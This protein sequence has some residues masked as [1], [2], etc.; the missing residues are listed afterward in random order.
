VLRE[1]FDPKGS[2]SPSKKTR[3]SDAAQNVNLEIPSDINP[4]LPTIIAKGRQLNSLLREIAESLQTDKSLFR[5]G[6]GLVS[7]RNGKIEHYS[8]ESMPKL[9]SDWANYVD[10]RGNGVFPPTTAAKAILYSIDGDDGI[11]PLERVVNVPTLRQDGT[12]LD[13]PGYDEAS[14]LFYHPVGD[15]PP[16]PEHPT[17]EDARAAAAWIMDMLCDFPFDASSL[18]NYLGLLLTFSMRQLCACVPMALLDAPIMGSGKSHLA[19]IACITATGGAAAFGVQLGSEEETRKNITSRLREGPSIIVMDTVEDTIS[20]P[21]LAM[22]L[23]SDVYEDR[24]LGQSRM[25]S[26]P[27]RAVFVAT[28]NNLRTGKDMPRRCF[29][30]KIDAN[31][32]QPWMRSGFKHD[33]PKYAIDNR[34]RTVTSLLTMARAW[35][36]AGRPKGGNPVLGG[37]TRPNSF[38]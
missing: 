24:L 36:C 21:T 28:G 23:T 6:G 15:I 16:I 22:C 8:S 26:L 10:F 12:L 30:I 13:V 33:L 25:L 17:Q 14:R 35:L 18:A 38:I 29:Y 37:Y 11:R 34:S 3:K 2:T 20:S 7:L 1:R 31:T 5:H 32:V 27:V 4:F 19:K 9:L